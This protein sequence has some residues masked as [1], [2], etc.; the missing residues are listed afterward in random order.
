MLEISL[1]KPRKA[2]LNPAA[3]SVPR[4]VQTNTHSAVDLDG[5]QVLYVV[6]GQ[7]LHDLLVVRQGGIDHLFFLFLHGQYFFF[8]G[9][10]GD[11]F[12]VVDGSFLSDAIGSVG[13]FDP[14]PPDSTRGRNGLPYRRP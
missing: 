7:F 10:A 5:K 13:G 14:L 2:S 4:R 6:P 11:H 9:A 8:D 3:F 12:D 1:A